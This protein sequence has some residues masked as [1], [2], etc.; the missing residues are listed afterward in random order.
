[1][2]RL[3][4]LSGTGT[5]IGKTHVGAALLG[6]LAVRGVR[7]LGYKP[8]ESGVTNDAT[9]DAARLRAASTL[10]V[11]L[12]YYGLR[13]PLGP[14][15]AARREGVR[16]DLAALV[17]ACGVARRAADVTIVELPGGLFSPLVAGTSNAAF[18]AQIGHDA[19]VLVAPDRL[20]VLHDVFA[21]DAA[22]RANGLTP[23]ALILSEPAT[24][25]AATGTHAD[26]LRQHT[27]LRVAAVG[28]APSDELARDP[29][30]GAI[31][32]ALIAMP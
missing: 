27:A 26:Y 1:M 11:Q 23:S 29:Q 6:A 7:A 24:P 30:L 20:G 19:L 28:R 14:H 9:S 12:P 21:C 2:G 8:I 17:T 5:E 16:L 4:I 18:A 31:V 15:E 13:T 10:Q 25:D 3:W 32:D 22:A